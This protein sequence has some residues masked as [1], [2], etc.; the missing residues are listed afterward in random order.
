MPPRKRTKEVVQKLV[1]EVFYK[2]LSLR[3]AAKN[4]DL[5]LAVARIAL[6]DDAVQYGFITKEQ[7]DEY[8][9]TAPT[10]GVDVRTKI[11][12]QLELS[13]I[14]S[15]AGIKSASNGLERLAD[16]ARRGGLATQEK[17]GMKVRKNLHKAR[18]YGSTSCCYGGTWFASQGERMTALLLKSY[19]LL[20]NIVEGENF[21][22]GFGRIRVDFYI[23]DSLIVE[24]HPIP[25][26]DFSRF[27]GDSPISTTEE[28][29]KDRTEKLGP[30]FKGNIVIIS[31]PSGKFSAME[32]YNNMPKLGI[33][34]TSWA[35]FLEKFRKI[36]VD[37]DLAEKQYTLELKDSLKEEEPPF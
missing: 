23:N 15:N 5:S 3:K 19:G 10:R 30:L 26:Q 31:A 2:H 28:Y 4:C 13:L 36:R 25:K 21:Q 17:H 16:Q 6:R 9:Q 11:Y 14:Y 1:D 20:E 37:I 35:E 33:K 12:T 22:K 24:Y 27:E 8:V 18:P 32:F 29:L 7:H 34:D